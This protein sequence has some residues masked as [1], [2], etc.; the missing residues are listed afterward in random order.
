GRQESSSLITDWK[1]S[2]DTAT[3]LD[4]DRTQHNLLWTDLKTGLQVRISAIEFADSPVVE[5]TMF[6]KNNGSAD[7]PILEE[8]N[9]LSFSFVV[10]GSGIP[11]IL[12]SKG[13]GDMDPYSLQKKPLNQLESFHL[14]GERGGKT[15][16]SIPFFDLLTAEGG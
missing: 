15:V 3:Q 8:V 2:A 7:T 6:F 13:C 16:D 11:T 1:K 14:S 12:Y 9:P 4:R 10:S 5:W